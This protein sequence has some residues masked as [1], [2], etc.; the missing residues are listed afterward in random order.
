MCIFGPLV[1][2][3]VSD[4]NLKLP[5]GSH[6]LLSCTCT[7]STLLSAFASFSSLLP[8]WPLSEFTGTVCVV[9]VIVFAPNFP[10]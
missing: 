5:S 10:K 8:S 3:A 2:T 1:F 6:S 4:L 9:R 7:A